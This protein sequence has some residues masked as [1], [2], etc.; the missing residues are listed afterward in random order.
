MKVTIINSPDEIKPKPSPVPPQ[1]ASEQSIPDDNKKEQQAKPI[2]KSPGERL[3][4]SPANHSVS[5][6]EVR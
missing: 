5:R 6:G 3:L 2:P 4:G 1:P